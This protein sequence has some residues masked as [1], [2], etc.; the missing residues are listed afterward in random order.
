VAGTA[1][2][3]TTAKKC[4]SSIYI[5]VVQASNAVSLNLNLNLSRRK[6]RLGTSKL[7]K[8]VCIQT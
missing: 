7:K 5:L 8:V 2:D 6:V 3:P 1:V 4:G